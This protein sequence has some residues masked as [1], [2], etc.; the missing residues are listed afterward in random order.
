M[1]NYSQYLEE[2]GVMKG[3]KQG[4]EEGKEEG[5]EEEK[6]AFLAKLEARHYNDSQIME[7]LEVDKTRLKF[8]RKR[9]Q[10]RL[11]VMADD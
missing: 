9:L 1:C 3:L 6:L 5:K 2:K 10:E 7:F 8:L 4:R 11:T